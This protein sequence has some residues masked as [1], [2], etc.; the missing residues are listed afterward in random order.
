MW[1]K[2][3][4][5][6]DATP[7]RPGPR[8]PS[9]WAWLQLLGLILVTAA[10]VGLWMT[11]PQA[12]PLAAIDGMAADA[13]MRWRGPIA[14]GTGYPVVLVAFDDK[15]AERFGAPAP[16]RE[17][18]ATLIDRL[19]AAG[20][21]LIA[22]DQPFPDT[23]PGDDALATAMRAGTRVLLPLN[24]A[25]VAAS[26]TSAAPSTSASP[27]AS[28]APVASAA[29]GIGPQDLAS[30][31][32]G[33]AEG[34]PR[35]AVT[36]EHLLAPPEPLRS[37][38]FALGHQI[39]L[40]D[41]DGSPR[42]VAAA[43][44]VGGQ[45]L[46]SLALRIAGDAMRQPWTEATLRWSRDVR[47]GSLVVPVD[48]QTRQTVNAYGPAGTFPTLSFSDVLDGH[49]PEEAIHNRIVIVGATTG[50]GGDFRPT[51]F[52]ALS[53]M[54]RWATV[55]DNILTSRVPMRPVWTAAAT[56]GALGVLPLLCVLLL[57][58]GRVWRGL[59]GVG[60]LTGLGLAG[61]QWAFEE[62][63]LLLPVAWPL[64]A[65]VASSTTA[66]LLRALGALMRRR[67][68]SRR[69][70]A[71][72]ERLSL[73]ARGADDGL[74]DWDVA[75]DR[76]DVSAR[77]RALMGLEDAA[78]DGIAGFSLA[79]DEAAAEAFRAALDA[80]VAGR[81]PRLHHV[82]RFHRAGQSRSLLVRGR[83]LVEGGRA[84]RVAGTL[85]DI[86]DVD[87]FHGLDAPKARDAMHDRATGLPN[88]ALFLELVAQRLATPV[89]GVP[90]AVA[91]LSLDGFRDFLD[92]HGLAA[93][94]AVLA[95]SAQRLAP[96]N[97]RPGRVLARVDVDRFALMFE[98]R[99]SP[100]GTLVER[101]PEWALARIEEP[102]PYDRIVPEEGRASAPGTPGA[103]GAPDAAAGVVRT[104]A[105]RLTACAGWAHTGQANF[106]PQDLVKA[107]ESAL[108]RAQLGGAG[109][110]H[111]FDAVAARF[112]PMHR[113]LQERIAPALAANEFELHYQPIVRL[114]D[115]G[116]LGFEALLRW[117]QPERGVL[118]PDAVVPAAEDSGQMPALGRWT[119]IEAALQARRWR[120]IGFRG[121]VAVNVSGA[122]WLMSE[123][124]VEA[125][126][127][128]AKALGG[129][130]EGPM[131]R[132]EIAE[133]GVTPLSPRP[134]S[135]RALSQLGIASSVDDFG[136]GGAS[137]ITLRRLPVDT[138][139][140]DRGLVL[141]LADDASAPDEVRAIVALARSLGWR[142]LAE[143][144]E[145]ERQ[146][147]LLE[148]LGV[149]AAQGSLFAKALPP[150]EVKRL[151]QTVP[152][153]KPSPEGAN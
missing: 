112:L 104:G 92:R 43:L 121:E 143:G 144:V 12:G 22:I 123:D 29:S 134:E 53:S 146:A 125:V 34:E 147:S 135:L 124:F 1:G 60:L 6:I 70:R 97:G 26:A 103:P 56:L 35:G 137:F 133:R 67:A 28:A 27:A 17:Q 14:P 117:N 110:V 145:D 79:L 68:E 113:W 129:G 39:E 41:A 51:A 11:R 108:A 107:A 151:I 149:I 25:E 90:V 93:G 152:W 5:R 59:L 109:H 74:W 127:D 13:Q 24:P 141:R 36:V 128:A 33:H 72:E 82:L 23:R 88:R 2:R 54:E 66:L 16:S 63:R 119:L 4:N 91:M 57:A 19:R 21:R 81:T 18:L 69:L 45:T 126:K 89:P 139:K 73:A 48:L 52:G 42:Q 31:S 99:V 132:L 37:A 62:E 115:R 111:L 131:L 3:Q 101:V 78:I 153:K 20:P 96:R 86:A 58:R 142:T 75:R 64:L 105:H 98:L 100:E 116:L 55:A 95:E 136:A 85:T 61:A 77:W 138:V 71:N 140:I 150:D 47:W 38:A 80:H 84:L 46:P 65:I 50:E 148:E 9:R 130:S 32:F 10:V 102:F 114:A 15:S 49:A 94:E 120:D 30:H 76:L 44:S 106:S 87:R 118:M 122:D 8:G 7:G 40:R 83:A